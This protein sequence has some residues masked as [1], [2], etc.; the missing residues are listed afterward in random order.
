MS[1]AMLNST[2]RRHSAQE[3]EDT[4]IPGRQYE[5]FDANIIGK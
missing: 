5:P 4:A 1:M 2:Y 3:R